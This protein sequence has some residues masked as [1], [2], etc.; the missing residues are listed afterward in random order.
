M[1]ISLEWIND[2]VDVLDLDPEWLAEKLTVVTAEIE[3]ICKIESD[4]ILDIDNKSLTNRPDL[5]CHYGFAREI[6]AI[7]G[8][9]LRLP[10]LIDMESIKVLDRSVLDIKLQDNGK[11]YRYTLAAIEGIK[12]M[13]SIGTLTDRLQRC[14]MK[15]TNLIVDLANYVMLDIGL[16]LHTF[17]AG[18]INE[19]RVYELSEPAAFKGLDGADRI[20][21]EG[22]LVIGSSGGPAAAAGIIGGEE[23]SVKDETESIILEAAVF[24]S[25]CIRRTSSSLGLRTD[26]SARFEKSL[27][28]SLTII[29]IGRYL[30]L[31]QQYQPDIMLSF[32]IQDIIQNETKAGAIEIEH[33]YVETY[34]GKAIE[35]ELVT[36]I[37]Q[38][39]GF[40][41]EYA[42]GR[43]VVSAPTYRA[44]KDI[45]CKADIVEEVLRLYGYENI[46]PKPFTTEISVFPDDTVTALNESIRKVLSAAQGFNEVHTYCWYDNDWLQKLGIKEA[47]TI[48]ISNSSVKQHEQLRTSIVPNLLNVAYQNRK[49]FEVIRVYE[50]GRIFKKQ[51][52][53]CYQPKMLAMLIFGAG[54]ESDVLGKFLELK[55]ICN[56]IAV[57][58]RRSLPVYKKS[59][60][61]EAWMDTEHQMDIYIDNT[62]IGSIYFINNKLVN[63]YGK[64]K[65]L[66][67]AELN[68]ERL[69]NLKEFPLIYD[70]VSKYPETYLDF[71]IL[72]GKEISYEAIEACV[73]SYENSIIKGFEY[74]GTYEGDKISEAM[75]STTIRL[76]LGNKE[77][78]LTLQEIN[79]L[80][81]EFV[82]HLEC[83]NMSLR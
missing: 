26:A 53:N 69:A 77:K 4:Y 37:L 61:I 36:D 52:E 19:I 42:E 34:L 65:Y 15:S 22:T 33:R 7:T 6:S 40:D 55:G 32:P 48:K 76:K 1:K 31:L 18:H 24:D 2:Y 28:T 44:T 50:I 66:I 62:L 10:E 70:I 16:P 73:E 45:T 72:T 57:K 60:N 27:D 68:L 13:K 23:T 8:R 83:F 74:I 79:I 67:A 49:N 82:S 38:R 80:K 46:E 9:Q 58:N 43:Y 59:N 81:D 14:G 5:W 56:E 17:D 35:S 54:M 20:L 63:I 78:T 25:I 71:S 51:D 64:N 75:K 47:D 41:T 3:D 12:P 30:K 11:C 29:S 39:L 21:H